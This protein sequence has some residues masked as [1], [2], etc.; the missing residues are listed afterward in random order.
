MDIEDKKQEYVRSNPFLVLL[1]TRIL[2]WQDGLA[3]IELRIRPDHHNRS[4]ILYGGVLSALL[5]HGGG[6]CGTFTEGAGFRP[7]V[8]VS[9][10]CNFIG[11]RS[12][13]TVRVIGRRVQAGRK[14]YFA[15]AKVVHEDGGLLATSSSVHRLRG[16][17]P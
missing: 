7:A 4:G 1:G 17:T 6:L 5:D 12:A 9:M 16:E 14:L 3:E 10:T 13:G 2:T 15:E 8:T 11:Q